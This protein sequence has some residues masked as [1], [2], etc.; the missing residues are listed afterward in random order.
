MWPIF[1]LLADVDETTHSRPDYP[2]KWTR[3][4]SKALA[5]LRR[6][7]GGHAVHVL[8]DDGSCGILNSD[9]SV[10]ATRL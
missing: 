10:R 6:G 9:G 7:R 3:E 8:N 2:A 4:Q 1:V 5:W